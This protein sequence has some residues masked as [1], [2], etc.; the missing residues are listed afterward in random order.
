MTDGMI[1]RHTHAQ[2]LGLTSMV[3]K[4]GIRKGKVGKEKNDRCVRRAGE[5]KGSKRERGRESIRLGSDDKEERD[6]S[7]HPSDQGT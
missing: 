5:E 6:G 2:R 3:E 4:R 7:R 1:V